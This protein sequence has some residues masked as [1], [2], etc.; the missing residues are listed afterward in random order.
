MRHLHCRFVVWSPVS[1]KAGR[2]CRPDNK[3]KMT[4]P[5]INKSVNAAGPVDEAQGVWA[6]HTT[7][8]RD[9]VCRRS[10]RYVGT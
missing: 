4:I 6:N 3:K 8:T 9:G 1:E 2:Y 10:P 7:P 5:G